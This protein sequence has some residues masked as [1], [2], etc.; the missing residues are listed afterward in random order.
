MSKRS[1]FSV[2]DVTDE[3]QYLSWVVHQTIFCAFN[4]YFFFMEGIFHVSPSIYIS[5]DYCY[6]TF[7]SL[8]I[9]L[10]HSRDFTPH[11]TRRQTLY[12]YVQ[13]CFF[14]PSAF[15]SLPAAGR[16][17]ALGAVAGREPALTPRASLV[18]D[19]R[20]RALRIQNHKSPRGGFPS[21]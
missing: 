19:R 7:V 21:T 5:F 18:P 2:S 12:Y 3:Q 6:V 1:S 11:S 13:L 14:G 15:F 20:P 4:L 9:K 17:R 16:S 8:F 10:R